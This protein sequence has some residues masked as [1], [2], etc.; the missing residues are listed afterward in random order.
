[1]SNDKQWSKGLPTSKSFK[2]IEEKNFEIEKKR[3]QIAT[4]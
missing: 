1:M 3:A 2:V 4:C